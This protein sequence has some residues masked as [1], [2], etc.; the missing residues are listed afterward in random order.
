MLL[1]DIAPRRRTLTRTAAAALL[2]AASFAP[3]MP[4]TAGLSSARAE[5]VTFNFENVN[6]YSPLPVT[7]GP[8]SVSATM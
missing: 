4:C 7:L 1:S 3:W 5:T 2:A 6:V 8:G